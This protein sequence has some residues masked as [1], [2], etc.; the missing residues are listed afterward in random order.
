MA[1]W[2]YMFVRIYSGNIIAI[3]GEEFKKKN[4]PEWESWLRERGLEGWELASQV[5][6]AALSVHATLKRP[7]GSIRNIDM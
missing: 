7:L 6:F 4:Q 3:N 1:L 2:E 5:S